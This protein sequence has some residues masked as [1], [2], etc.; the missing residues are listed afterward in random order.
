MNKLN[1]ILI[2]IFISLLVIIPILYFTDDFMC[3]SAW[4]VEDGGFDSIIDKW[5]E[6]LKNGVLKFYNS[7]EVDTISADMSAGEDV[8]LVVAQCH[9][10]GIQFKTRVCGV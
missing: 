1:F 7:A 2:S 4:K 10:L 3:G 8:R 5:S 6:I 9:A